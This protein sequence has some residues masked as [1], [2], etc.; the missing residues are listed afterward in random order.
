MSINLTVIKALDDRAVRESIAVVRQVNVED[1][2]R[3]TPCSAWN[4]GQLLAHMTAQHRGFAAAARGDG[5]D[6]THWKAE[7]PGPEDVG[8]YVAAAEA[9]LAAFTE[10]GTEDQ[11]FALP[12]FG[13]GAVFPAIQAI[14]FHLLDYVVHAWDVTRVL[15]LPFTADPDVLDAA[16][17]IALAVPD[18][19]RRTQPGSAFAPSL[20]SPT[21]SNALTRIL[22]HLG[23]PLSW[24]PAV[25]SHGSAEMGS[26]WDGC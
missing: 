25:R 22:M 16:L 14:G 1:L 7:A 6:L 21:D 23:R 24:G 8:R 3:P 20:P 19:A 5:G 18:G 4:L 2:T 13:T 9:V 17:P 12:E 15:D 11:E 26:A 10:V